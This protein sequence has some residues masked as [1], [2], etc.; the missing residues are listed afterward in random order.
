MQSHLALAWLLLTSAV[1]AAPEPKKVI[2]L[3]D[4]IEITQKSMKDPKTIELRKQYWK[5]TLEDI[6][7]MRIPTFKD[8]VESEMKIAEAAEPDRFTKLKTQRFEG[9]P[10]WDRLLQDWSEDIQ[11]YLDTVNSQE[12][13]SMSNYGRATGTK[14]DAKETTPKSS[15]TETKPLQQQAQQQTQT[16]QQPVQQLPVPQP[17]EPGEEVL[18]YTDLSD[19]SKNLLVVTTASLPWMTGTAV[20]PLLRAAYLTHGRK[21]AGGSSTLMVPFLERDEDQTRVYGKIRFKAPAEQEDYI[22]NWLRESAG[23]EDAAADLRIKFYTAWQNKAENSIYSMGDITALLDDEDYDICILE[24]VEH[25]NWYRAPGESWTKKFRH[26]IGILHTN[27]FS[28][29]L[30]QPA[31]I[32]RAPG[33]K[34]LCSWMCRAHCHRVIKLSG[35]LEQMAPEKE[36]VENVHGVRGTFLDIGKRQRDSPSPVM[37][38]EA[39]P[40]VYFIGKLLWSKGL[41]SLME[42]L[43]YAE[44]SANLDVK[45]DM[46]GGGPDKDAAAERSKTLEL[47]M[48]FH[49]PL[50]HSELADTHKIF[51]NPSTS[52]VLCTTTAESLAMGK[53]A[54]I[55]S[56]PSNDFFAQFPNCLVY[57]NKEEFVGNLYYAMTHAPEPLSEEFSYILSW[58]AATQRLMAAGCIPKKE[59]E[60]LDQATQSG[61]A[62][63]EITLPPLV[64]SEQGRK[65]LS[66]MLRFSR[67]RYR[68]FRNRLAQ[69]ITDNKILPKPMQERLI[70]ELDKRLD[71]DID[72][73]L[74]SP[75]LRLK[76]SP[77]ELDKSL[78]ELYDGIS[79]SPSGDIFRLIGGGGSVGMQNLYMRRRAEKDRRPKMRDGF[80]GPDIFP[81]YV[82]H[83]DHQN[84][85][86]VSQF[87]RRSL[88]QNIPELK[89]DG[90]DRA[91]K[92]CYGRQS[93]RQS[94]SVQPWTG[95]RRP[96][97]NHN[98]KFSI[99]I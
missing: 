40:T 54:I 27:Y 52:E 70:A 49:G 87:V 51:V 47:D 64:E 66:T 35:T 2:S 15:Q 69:E 37:A 97:R 94:L 33:M 72:E 45:V 4:S 77:A 31:A 46:Y 78:L 13:Y 65:G 68:Q 22:R 91:P 93:S 62:E 42:L 99:L 9:F 90:D 18:D 12:G 14:E 23:M 60:M 75:K 80:S 92:M 28:Y 58:E 86:S 59:A 16:Q 53:F 19:L 67:L 56:H 73:L 43:K 36:L 83:N 84:P 38:A 41:G 76:L 98:S 88:R 24:E 55:P 29:A 57:S 50:D 48:P 63:I 71:L 34:L 95:L 85:S 17:A 3:K 7:N 74:D 1:Q 11:E 44:E 30:D 39:S 61:D 89:S 6:K 82:D 8:M 26:V 81:S 5:S 21:P 79:R 20:N 96:P 10:S 32:I 25:L